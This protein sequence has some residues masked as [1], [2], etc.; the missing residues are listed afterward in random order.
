[1]LSQQTT[2]QGFTQA[3]AHPLIDELQTAL[4]FIQSAHESAKDSN[5]AQAHPE[6]YTDICD[7][8]HHCQSAIDALNEI[9]ESIND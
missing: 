1:M 2:T 5:L 3:Q 4:N 7:A 6:A 8:L 9:E